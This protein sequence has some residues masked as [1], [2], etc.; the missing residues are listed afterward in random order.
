MKLLVVGGGGREHAIIKSLKKN[1]NVEQIFAL[2][3]NAGMEKDATC[4]SSGYEVSYCSKCGGA[5]TRYIPELGH[6][7]GENYI[8][9][10]YPT[11][12]QDGYKSQHCQNCDDKINVITISAKGHR[13]NYVEVTEPSC[14]KHGVSL[15]DCLDCP[16]ITVIKHPETGHV[17]VDG[18]CLN[19]GESDGTAEPEQPEIFD[20]CKHSYSNWF[21]VKQATCTEGG[22]KESSCR[23]CGDIIQETIPAMGHSLVDGYCENCDYTENTGNNND[24]NEPSDPSDN[25]DCNCHKGG[26]FWKLIL[27]FQKLFGANKTCDCGVAHY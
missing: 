27:F 22:L 14:T 10:E 20:E 6:I 3:G 2:P 26:F 25:C 23:Y 9:D 12:T 16:E 24:N 21:V 17:F 7:Y 4:V 19:C 18:V 5:Q 1:P 15:A 8:I 13:F 11:C